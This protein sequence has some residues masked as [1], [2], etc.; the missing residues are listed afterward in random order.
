MNVIYYPT[1]YIQYFLRVRNNSRDVSDS[2]RGL[3]SNVWYVDTCITYMKYS[4]YLY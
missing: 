3:R 4:L 2:A 1:F